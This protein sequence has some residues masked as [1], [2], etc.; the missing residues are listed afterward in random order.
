MTR[1]SSASPAWSP[2]CVATIGLPLV[3]TAATAVDNQLII[4]FANDMAL[5]ER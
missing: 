4:C 3:A 5:F 2:E 1:T